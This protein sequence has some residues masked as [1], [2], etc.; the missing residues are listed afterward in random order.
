MED[1]RSKLYGDKRMQIESYIGNNMQ[2]LHFHNASYTSSMHPQTCN[3]A[4]FKKE[5]S[6]YDTTSK[7][8]TFSDLELKR[9]KRVVG[10][11]AYAVEG[12]LKGSLKKSFKWI[13]DRC[14]KVVYGW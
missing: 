4:K 9:K 8:W 2:D 5:K 1:F 12:K 10:Y 13:K 11:K 6:T 3:D 14:N 7:T